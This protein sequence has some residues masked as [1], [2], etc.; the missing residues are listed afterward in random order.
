MTVLSAKDA[1]RNCNEYN[2]ALLKCYEFEKLVFKSIR[3]VSSKGIYCIE[4]RYD[5]SNLREGFI[6]DLL[7]LGFD[8]K[9]LEID[10]INLLCISWSVTNG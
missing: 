5:K 6:E 8:V 3:E 4:I 1:A 7:N 2:K 10:G 9:V